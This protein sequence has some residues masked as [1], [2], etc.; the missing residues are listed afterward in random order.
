MTTTPAGSAGTLLD[1]VHAYAREVRAH[2]ADL[3]PEQVDDLT[4]GLEADL[5]EALADRPGRAAR[6]D[7]AGTRVL[8]VAAAFGPSARYAA[9]LRTAAGL[10]VAP[11]PAPSH[12]AGL[13][14]AL[15]TGWW[16]LAT[17][18]ARLWRPVTSTPQ[19]ASLR[20]FSHA[21]RP[22]WWVLR[23]WVAGVVLA[24]VVGA[25]GSLSLVPGDRTALL[26]AVAGAVLSVQW[27]RGRWMP[28]SWVPAAVGVA[29]VV[30][31][32]L[33]VPAVLDTAA[34]AR[35]VIVQGESYSA[36]FADGTA[37]VNV[38]GGGYGD[39]G[40]DGVWVDGMQVSNLFVF[41]A[42]GQPLRDVQVFDDRGRP[43]RTVGDQGVHQAW[44]VPEVEGTWYFQP[45]VSDDGRERWNV[46][47]L[48]AVADDAV[49]LM[50]DDRPRP[51][52][53][54]RLTTLPWPFL[55]APTSITS[56]APSAPSAPSAP[57]PGEAPAPSE[58]PQDPA[59]PAP[60]TTT[61][62]TPVTT[63]PSPVLEAGSP[64]RP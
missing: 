29:S 16:V 14:R 43:V 30:L 62:R 33:A 39:P 42:Q 59:V 60:G 52:T 32:V 58:A 49:D 51:A 46:Y 41:D 18:W 63:T 3:D 27:G 37:A 38:A 61:G 35:P 54:E 50:G 13:R 25:T 55:L 26:L 45:A 56:T 48:R 23:G 44:A 5:A 24:L 17:G 6:T 28:W 20:E 22:V 4:D 19:W 2:L 34:G 8:D 9:E 64:E 10:P 11:P 40:S 53:G 31:A 7:A 21:V 57:E 15:L 47:P 36:G 12:R 1:H